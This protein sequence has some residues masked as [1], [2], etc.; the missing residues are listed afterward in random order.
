MVT[1]LAEQASQQASLQHTNASAI[2][3]VTLY[4]ATF[5]L[6][7]AD[8]LVISASLYKVAMLSPLCC[9]YHFSPFALNC[10]FFILIFLFSVCVCSHCILVCIHF[11]D[12]S[13]TCAFA[14]SRAGSTQH[15][16]CILNAKNTK[17]TLTEFMC[18]HW[19]RDCIATPI[20]VTSTSE[21]KWQLAT[22]SL[23]YSIRLQF[24]WQ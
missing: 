21:P 23:P 2:I 5:L 14:R 22:F 19:H 6:G 20:R 18:W 8:E 9:C 1:R 3:D 12:E 17:P 24:I 16:R 11:M 4:R 10:F 15:V 7:E 13:S